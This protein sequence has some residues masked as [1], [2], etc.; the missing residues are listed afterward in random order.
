MGCYIVYILLLVVC[1]CAAL[2]SGIEVFSHALM[3]PC[4]LSCGCRGIFLLSNLQVHATQNYV[5]WEGGGKQV[6]FRLEMIGNIYL[7]LEKMQVRNILR[8]YVTRQT[9][10]F[11][12]LILG[13]FL[14]HNE[15]VCLL[16]H[17]KAPKNAS[18]Q[19]CDTT[20]Q[21]LLLSP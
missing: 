5:C 21:F 13:N 17:G 16:L 12:T 4:C 3:T 11:G 8:M 2:Y 1:L 10:S 19:K 20:M 7:E 15:N 9:C 18:Q 14:L 6:C